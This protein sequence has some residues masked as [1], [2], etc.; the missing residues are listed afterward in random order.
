MPHPPTSATP[1]VTTFLLEVENEPRVV[2][3]FVE[4][5]CIQGW[6]DQSLQNIYQTQY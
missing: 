4:G 6:M 3:N 2:G 1:L 5:D